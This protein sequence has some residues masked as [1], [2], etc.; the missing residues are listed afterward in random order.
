MVEV[1]FAQP[2]ARTRE[3][4]FTDLCNRR[5]HAEK[6]KATQAGKS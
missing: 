2:L 1:F 3:L 4:R 6:G 5:Q